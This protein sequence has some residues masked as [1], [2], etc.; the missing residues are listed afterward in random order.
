MNF[1]SDNYYGVHPSIFDAMLAA[2]T[3]TAGAYGHDTFSATLQV[4]LSELFE[5][6]VRVWQTS[7][8]TVANCICVSALC[9]PY[10]VVYTA[11]ASHMVNDECTAPGLFT[12][13][14]KFVT[15][16]AA[17]SKIDL[18]A[19]RAE[20][21]RARGNPPHGG[22]PACISIAQS[23]ELGRVYTVEELRQIGDTARELGLGFHMDGARFGNALV[24]LG[25][26]PAEMTWKVGVQLLSFGATKNGGLM[27]ELIIAFDGKYADEIEFLHKR[28]GQLMSKTRYFAAQFIA[29][30]DN[31]LWISLA[32]HA[33]EM[34]Q[35][36][37][38]EIE[39]LD[40]VTVV[41]PVEANEIFV[42]ME[43]AVAEG[44]WAAGVE[45]YEWDVDVSL[46]RLVTAWATTDEAIQGF[47][48]AAKAIKG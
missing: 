11:Q 44:L 40:N 1:K 29:Y 13:G 28:A 33:N 10:G 41:P 17:P 5:R 19:V 12:G 9:P 4:R 15:S 2:N 35:K 8:G 45:F 7:T 43:R 48:N 37:V 38:G 39:K 3:G 14:A 32:K 31:G 30:L 46:Y 23:T 6:D 26:T 42:T 25:C 36:L 18:A 47:V 16:T 21:A 22:H 34:A 27:G 24:A 20:V